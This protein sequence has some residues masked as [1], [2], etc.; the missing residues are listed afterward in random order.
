M[1]RTIVFML[2]LCT[3]TMV[4]AQG[5]NDI[6]NPQRSQGESPRQSRGVP[7][8]AESVNISGNLTIARGMIAVNSNDVTYIAGGLQ[9]FVGFIDGLREGAT[10][11]LEGNAYP[12][13]QNDAVKFL[14]VQKM[15]L[16]GRDYDLARPQPNF[17]NERPRQMPRQTPQQ[18]QRQMPR[19][20]P[21]QM[22]RHMPQQ[23]RNRGR[24]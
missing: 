13:P 4:F 16:N 8:N 22:P 9:R 20:M 15:T 11:T 12:V 3:I 19:H 10:V 1:K 18:M 14:A 24:R 6:Q 5:S 2:V 17:Q 23:D 7:R 21:R